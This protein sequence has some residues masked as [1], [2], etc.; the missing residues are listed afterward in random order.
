MRSAFKILSF[1][2]FIVFFSA[3]VF[4][5]VMSDESLGKLM[6]G[7]SR[8][9]SGQVSKKGSGDTYRK[10]LAK[11]QYPYAVVVTCSD[12]RVAPE[13][14][15]DEELGKIF[16][17]RTAGNVVDAIALG[18]IEYGVEHLHSPLVVVLG[19]ESCGAVKAAVDLKGE[20]EGNI[21]AI[22]KKIIP[23]VE[24]A[25]T[26]IKQGED[27]YYLS[28]IEN[29]RNMVREI[30]AKSPIIT[31]AA[32]EGKVKLVG[33]FYSISSGKVETVTVK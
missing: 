24:K 23:S 5:E 30:S 26:S 21:G 19:H 22:L 28:T 8:Y 16:V 33:A 15:F 4:A 9:V 27:L 31:H 6:Q 20:P 17:V 7:N 3:V 18:S 14:I 13:I 11:G 10:E 32:H 2:M 29:V 25:K 12:S 1:F